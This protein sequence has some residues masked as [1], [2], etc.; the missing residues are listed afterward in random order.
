MI[1]LRNCTKVAK[2]IKKSRKTVQTWLKIFNIGGLEELI[3]NSPPGRPS[4][5]SQSQKD[6]LKLDIMTHPRE[7]GYEFSNWEGK[8]VAEHIHVKFG[9]ILT[10]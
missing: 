6:E 5:L 7:L 4:R 1:E 8:S 3:P 9:V 10:V 2:L